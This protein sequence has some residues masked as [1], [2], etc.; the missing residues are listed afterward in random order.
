MRTTSLI[1][2]E[3]LAGSELKGFIAGAG[4]PVDSY[5]N[6][7]FLRALTLHPEA[8]EIAVLAD[9]LNEYLPACLGARKQNSAKK[10]I[11]VHLAFILLN[12]AYCT[13]T[14]QFLVVPMTKSEYSTNYF[15]KQFSYR[16][17]R[18]V[19]DGLCFVGVLTKFKG[20]K[21]SSEPMATRY[22][23]STELQL[24][25]I[26]LALCAQ[27]PFVPPYVEIRQ[28]FEDWQGVFSKPEMA[29]L[30]QINKFM[31]EHAWA[32]KGPVRLKYKGDIFH[33]GRL[34]TRFQNLP[35]RKI[36]IRQ[37]TLING[38][39][40]CEV[41][42]S[43]NHL[44]LALAMMTGEDAG[45][46]PYQEIGDACHLLRSEIKEFFTKAIGADSKEKAFSAMYISRMTKA[47][48]E[49]IERAFLQRFPAIPLY[50]GLGTN[51]QSIEGA[52]MKEIMLR[53]VKDQIV[54]LPIHDAVAVQAKHRAWA[55]SVMTEVWLWNAGRAGCMAYPRVKA[56]RA[57]IKHQA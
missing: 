7:A 45:E 14:R 50:E 40:I 16:A 27:E 1:A 20:A 11:E 42:Y 30:E 25:L 46:D 32:C 57:V 8:T 17:V 28:P 21:Y 31:I 53:G 19:L 29:E 6:H 51:L 36:P 18:A 22:W 55:E 38:E 4:A 43:A 12:L 47:K 35:S 15:L 48:I 33:S 26:S 10:T 9:L 44:R 37:N 24:K 5:E 2:P 13:L 3:F 56:S 52:I 54:A 49:I 23:P 39:P 41:D 34:Y